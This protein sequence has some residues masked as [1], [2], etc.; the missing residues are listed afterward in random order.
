[1]FALAVQ[2]AHKLTNKQ[3]AKILMLLQRREREAGGKSTATSFL[4]CSSQLSLCL[5]CCLLILLSFCIFKNFP[6]VFDE[7]SPEGAKSLWEEG[8]EC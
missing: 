7:A 1:M 6:C 3:F 4:I 8:I 5:K 2:L